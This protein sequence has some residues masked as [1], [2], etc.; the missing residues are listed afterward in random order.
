MSDPILRLEDV[1]K[2]FGGILAVDSVSLTLK[3]GEIVGLIGP[4]G[5]GKTTLVNL[6]T[7]AHHPD[8]GKITFQGEDVTN[9]Q[10]YQAARRG[11][12]RTFQIVQ[13]FPDMTVLDNV[14]AGALF[15]ADIVRLPD[16]REA[17]R[18]HL[19]FVGLEKLANTPASALTLPS[20]KRLELAKSLAMN[21][22]VLLLDE[23]NAG[24]NTSEIDGA[25]ELIRK[26]SER[27]ITILIIEHLMK[28][29]L[30]VSQ[31]IFVLHHGALIAEGPP[32]KVVKDQRVIEAYLGEKYA[33][34]FKAFGNA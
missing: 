24:L 28:V 32:D 10:P 4:N 23:V 22:K 7:G 30:T 16:A 11:L 27:G 26:I 17:A 19:A 14:A 8:S 15:G 12:C 29:V 18:E 33:K 2:R 31:R 25:L 20:R 3:Q 34:R 5:A 1:S 13:P 6:I 9:Q 21:P